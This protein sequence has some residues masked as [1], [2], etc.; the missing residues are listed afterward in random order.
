MSDSQRLERGYRRLVALFPR[1]FRH[2][3][4]DEIVAVLMATAREGQR[5][6]GPAE[7]AD[8]IRGALR[9]HRGPRLPRALLL[10]VRMAYAGAAAELAVLIALLVTLAGLTSATI[11]S[12]P[13]FSVAEWRAVLL[14]TH[15]PAAEAGAPVLLALWIWLACANARGNHAGRV[16]FWVAWGIIKVGIAAE[17]IAVIAVYGIGGAVALAALVVIHF[18]AMALIFY[19]S[20][21]PLP[22][23]PHRQLDP[24]QR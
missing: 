16:A 24:A 18:A 1:A 2:E 14:L 21:D 7:S 11:R 17:A 9:M 8:L 6:V 23:R 5:R 3:S 22:Y 12:H 4:E 20:K 10:P 15:L 19:P 13:D